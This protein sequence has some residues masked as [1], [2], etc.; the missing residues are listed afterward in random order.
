VPWFKGVAVQASVGLC[1]AHAN[2]LHR[3]GL[4]SLGS[5][6]RTRHWPILRQALVLWVCSTSTVPRIRE[7]GRM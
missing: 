5:L 6:R 7:L 3:G 4:S 1:M 2:P